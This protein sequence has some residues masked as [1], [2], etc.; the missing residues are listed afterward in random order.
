MKLRVVLL[1]L[2]VSI[3]LHC[4]IAPSLVAQCSYPGNTTLLETWEANAEVDIVNTTVP[5]GP[6][7]TAVTNW[8]DTLFGAET[9]GCNLPEFWQNVSGT[10]RINMT[11]GPIPNNPNCPAGSICITRGLTQFDLATFDSNNRL[12]S[13]P[14]TINSSMTAAAA[15]TEVIA[16]EMGHTLGLADCAFPS[17]PVNSSVM[18]SAVNTPG[19]TINSTVGQPGPTGCDLFSLVEFNP[20]YQCQPPPPPPV[21][22][23]C[24]P[25]D[26][27][28]QPVCSSIIIDVGGNGFSLTNA[29]N[30]VL[31]DISGT[32]RPVQIGWTAQGSNIAFL[33]LPGI[34]GLVHNGRQLFGNFTFQPQSNNPNGFAALAV[35]DDPKN[36]GNGDGLIDSRDT[37]YPYLRLWI[38]ANHDGICQPEEMHTLASLG[39]TSISLNY[40]LDRRVDQYGNVLRYRGKL[41]TETPS[42]SAVN[43]TAYDVFFVTLTTTAAKH[44]ARAKVK[45][46][47]PPPVLVGAM[48]QG[49][50]PASH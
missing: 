50:S 8:N 39:V 22:D 13:V 31:F 9:I 30:G 1:C 49:Y 21:D 14:T 20:A 11:F 2:A 5:S 26:G 45:S 3:L 6:V 17:C 46:C 18:E 15:E 32:G 37:I 19:T 35:Y 38:D 24:P 41:N 33:A 36:G 25:A 4:S 29:A 27:E 16:H 34:D 7:T 48:N 40:K 12:L 44:K 28:V 42:G 23:P 10:A 43:R 47:V